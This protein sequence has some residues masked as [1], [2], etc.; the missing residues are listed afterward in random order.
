MKI[1]SS[2]ILIFALVSCAA[3]P[4][5]RGS[6]ADALRQWGSLREA[7]RDGLTEAR[8]D[9]GVVAKPGVFAV[10]AA[11]DLDGEITIA[12]GQVFVSRV[13]AGKIETGS[14]G[15]A[16]VLIAADVSEWTEVTVS[17]DVGPS[18]LDEFLAA[19][20]VEVGL[21][22]ARPFPFVVEGQLRH[23]KVHVI[24]G[25]CPIR[26]R[27]L[28]AR[29]TTPPYE[30]HF[31]VVRG[32]LV[33]IHARDSVGQ[34]THHGTATHTHAIL[35]APDAFTGHVESVGLAKGAVLRLPATGAR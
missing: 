32:R 27:M 6:N 1:T 24:A 15:E 23:L 35:G 33:G 11:A 29:M 18:Q 2:G 14:A 12:D 22:A 34:L 7:L 20:A 16:T 9:V 25:Q 31:D 17:E 13:R 30:Q 5:D 19:R 4:G 10:G 3:A 26:A 8:V 21:D 28:G